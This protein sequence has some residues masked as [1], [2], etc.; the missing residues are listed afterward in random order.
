MILKNKNAVIYGAGG[1]LGGAVAKALAAAGAKVFLTGPNQQSIK[2][3]ADEIIASGGLAKTAIVDAFNEVAIEQHLQQMVSIAGIVDI[4]FNA[5]GVDVVQNIP[6]TEISAG[7]FVNPITL[8]MQTRFMTA[9][10]AA[11]VMMKQK[12]GV[13]LSLTATPAGIGYPLTGG[14][15]PACS[16]VESFSRT[17]ASEL[18]VYGIRVVN[19]RSGGSP[20][21][22]V[23]KS[24]I[25]AMPD[26][27]DPIIKKME[28]DTML[29]KLPLMADIAN[30]AVFLASDLAGQITG[31]TIDVTGGTTAALNYRVNRLD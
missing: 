8:T 1:S 13:I 11:R 10:A 28:G 2:K 20:D 29:K 3:V 9:I 16:A 19:I 31:V 6:L 22:R 21:S 24:A 14:F 15:G 5:V 27:M 7:D 25:D 4:S 18:G 17:L 30:T 26:V 23:F 12:S